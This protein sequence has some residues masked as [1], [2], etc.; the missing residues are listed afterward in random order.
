MDELVD[1][2]GDVPAVPSWRKEMFY[3]SINTRADNPEGYRDAEYPQ[4]CF[5]VA[6]CEFAAMRPL[7]L[8]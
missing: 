7:N 4:T 6:R 2:C 8:I 5:Q 3:A 1:L